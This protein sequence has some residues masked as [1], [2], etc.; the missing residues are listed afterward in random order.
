M[1]SPRVF[2]NAVKN[3]RAG[4]ERTLPAYSTIDGRFADIL[5]LSLCS[6]RVGAECAAMPFSKDDRIER[7]GLQTVLFAQASNA[8]ARTMS[9]KNRTVSLTIFGSA[10]TAPGPYAKRIDGPAPGLF[11]RGH[12]QGTIGLKSN[13]NFADIA[14]RANA[15][16]GQP[17]YHTLSK[18]NILKILRFLN[19]P[20]RQNE[21][22]G[23]RL[24][25]IFQSRS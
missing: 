5:A 20:S 8:F 16:A 18:H 14:P 6:N 23:C 1:S 4:T 24:P 17:R 22:R 13:L 12:L 19:D 10:H 25:G 15:L 9:G 2:R 11:R 3:L 7:S 21:D